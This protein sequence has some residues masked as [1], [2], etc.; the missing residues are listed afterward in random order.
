MK[1]FSLRAAR[2]G[3]ELAESTL[4]EKLDGLQRTAYSEGLAR[5]VLRAAEPDSRILQELD[6][7]E[8]AR[9]KAKV[10]G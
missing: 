8:A 2:L 6:R 3:F 1:N 5:E 10:P 9:D 7:Q 4:A